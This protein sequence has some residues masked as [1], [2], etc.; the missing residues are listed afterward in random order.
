MPTIGVS[1]W[2]VRRLLGP[3]YPGLGLTPASRPSDDCFG[4]GELDLLDLPGAMRAG[5]R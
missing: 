3:L 4:P 5:I 2:S 1:T